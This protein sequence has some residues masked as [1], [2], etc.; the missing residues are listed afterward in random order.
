[1]NVGKIPNGKSRGRPASVGKM[2]FLPGNTHLSG[3]S[4]NHKDALPGKLNEDP[5]SSRRYVLCG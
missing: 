2:L 5:K 4:L 3:K 1:M